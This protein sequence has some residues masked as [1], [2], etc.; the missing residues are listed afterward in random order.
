MGPG[1]GC[2]PRRNLRV[3]GPAVAKAMVPRVLESLTG[4]SLMLRL[5]QG[6]E[7]AG[8]P[9]M[10][11]CTTKLGTTRKKDAALPAPIVALP[12]YP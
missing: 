4:S 1:C 5:S 3:L 7:T 11:N 8:S 12:K 10:P 2:A 9:A 6:C